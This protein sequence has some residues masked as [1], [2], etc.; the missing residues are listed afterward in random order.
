MHASVRRRSLDIAWRAQPASM[1]FDRGDS[2]SP[3]LLLPPEVRAA[4]DRVVAR[5]HPL[6]DCRLGRPTLG[7]KCGCNE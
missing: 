3:W 1:R 5:G 7:V 6:G 2:A 4:F